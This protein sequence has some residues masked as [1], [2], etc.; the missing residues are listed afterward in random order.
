MSTLSIRSKDII[1]ELQTVSN[2]F[3]NDEFTT[4]IKDDIL[5]LACVIVVV[6]DFNSTLRHLVENATVERIIHRVELLNQLIS[7]F[8]AP[9]NFAF[10]D[11]IVSDQVSHEVL[12]DIALS[13]LQTRLLDELENA[14]VINHVL[15]VLF[16]TQLMACFFEFMVAEP[17][18]PKP[19]ALAQE[20]ISA[21]AATE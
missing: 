18:P 7:C 9:G 20:K 17:L 6:F 3:I 11:F 21:A 19:G 8:L 2:A 10:L 1:K 15:D 4:F 13:F 16:I 12:H 5:F 14:Q